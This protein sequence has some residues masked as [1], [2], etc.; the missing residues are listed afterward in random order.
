MKIKN[1]KE[2]Y[3]LKM[4]LNILLFSFICLLS[5]EKA[6]IRKIQISNKIRKTSVS[7]EDIKNINNTIILRKEKYVYITNTIDENGRLFVVSSRNS[8]NE[9]YVSGLDNNGRNYFE[10]KIQIFTFDKEISR[11]N[12][13]SL[14]ININNKK[15]LL[16][17]TKYYSELLNLSPL[18][19]NNNL[20]KKS[21]EIA[22]FKIFSN[23]NS[24]FSSKGNYLYLFYIDN[25]DNLV[26][27][28]GRINIRNE[29]FSYDCY[30]YRHDIQVAES[31][32][33]SCFKTTNFIN[34]FYLNSNEK[35]TI[36]IFDQD[37]YT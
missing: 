19:P 9:T 22:P 1:K 12:G 28:E 30:H 13:N 37:F 23:I 14:I 31:D 32:I 6:N 35:L 7:D 2:K 18:L 17:I 33:I 36:T 3:N 29:S 27:S 25:N 26:L 8:T 21:S 34:C 5:V 11:E 10:E 16:S 15:Y 24:L 20:Y 4:Y